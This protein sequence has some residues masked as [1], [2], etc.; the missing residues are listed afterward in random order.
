[1]A[2]VAMMRMIEVRTMRM[3]SQMVWKVPK[4]KWEESCCAAMNGLVLENWANL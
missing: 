4:R 2:V 3:M 1:M